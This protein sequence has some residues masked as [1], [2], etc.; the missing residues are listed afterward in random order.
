MVLEL[1]EVL[2]IDEVGPAV[3]NGP[4]TGEAVD[5][6]VDEVLLLDDDVVLEEEVEVTIAVLFRG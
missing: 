2:I 5:I 6:V 3:C 1:V 4:A